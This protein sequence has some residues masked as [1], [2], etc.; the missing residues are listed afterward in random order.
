TALDG[1][2]I[3]ANYFQHIPYL[4]SVLEEN[5]N[6]DFVSAGAI[7]IEPI[8]IYSKKYKSLKDLPKNGT[9]IMRDAVAEQGRI[10]SIFEKEGV[11]KLKEG[12]K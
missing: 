5:P 7:H 9:V 3:D 10:L 2:E 6:Y 8:G 11:I 12:V 4:D 1:K